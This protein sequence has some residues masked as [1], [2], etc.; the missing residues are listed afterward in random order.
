MQVRYVLWG[1]ACAL[2]VACMPPAPPPRAP[3][4]PPVAK[5]S[6]DFK[7]QP[8][9]DGQTKKTRELT[10]AVVYPTLMD[11]DATFGDTYRKFGKAF[12]KSVATDLDRV[13]AAKGI[14][15]S[16]P[17]SS[18]DEIPYPDKRSADLALT[19]NV[20]VTTT[21]LYAP[22]KLVGDDSHVDYS[23][24]PFKVSVQGFVSFELREPMSREKLWV[25]RLDFDVE[26]AQ[27]VEAHAVKP[28]LNQLGVAERY[29]I[30]ERV[31]DGRQDALAKVLTRWY[32]TILDKA[33]L[34]LD[35]DEMVNMKTQV[36]E[37]RQLKRY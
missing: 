15:V 23:E 35:V 25:K 28:V 1:L 13:L 32:P 12:A 5:E 26:D 22:A 8:A 21:F 33:W 17:Y 24:R 2:S 36:E 7:W 16:G 29:D 37:I 30:G 18:Y 10:V 6:F 3:A 34:Y 4:T 9:N 11:N 31:Y 20:V 19:P 14:K 27:G